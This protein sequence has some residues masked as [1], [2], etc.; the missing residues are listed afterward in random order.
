MNN[1][2]KHLQL[3]KLSSYGVILSLLIHGCGTPQPPQ[4]SA[5]EVE[6]AEPSTQVVEILAEGLT[7]QAPDSIP[8][9]W[10]IFRF[11]NPTNMVHLITI[12]WYPGG[13]GVKEHQDTLA[14]IFQN[15]MDQINGKQLSAPE[16]GTD[17]PAWFGEVKFLGGPALLSPGHTSE[18]MVKL[19]PGKYVLEC[20]VKTD[21]VFHSYNPDPQTYGMAREIMVTEEA[22]GLQPPQADLSINL[23]AADGIQVEGDPTPGEHWVEVNMMDQQL[24]ENFLGHDVHLVRLA[25][26]TDLEQLGAWMSWANPT[27]LQ[28]PAPAEFLGGT[29]EMPAG[30]KAYFKISLEPGS[31]AWVAEIPNPASHNMLVEFEVKE[32]AM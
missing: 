29:N 25:E 2:I 9:G 5:T 12:A 27:G 8:S 26:D 15:V 17:V 13:R 10:S 4:D 22:S 23:S 19:D 30:H 6:T 3:S 18:V 1:F 16:V 28:T 21:G 32:E 24:Y 31:Y 20:Y 11:D 14:P 7:I